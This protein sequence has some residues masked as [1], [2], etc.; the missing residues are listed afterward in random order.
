MRSRLS[1]L[2]CAACGR[3]L[4]AD[5]LQTLCPECG[6]VL[7]AR[8]DMASLRRAHRDELSARKGRMWRW[9]EALPVL[10][11][12]CVVSLGEGATP[13]LHAERIGERIGAPRLF[14]KDESGNPTGSFK[15]RGLSVAVSKAK[16]LGARSL[17]IPTAGNAGGALAAYAARAGIPADV[18][19]PID[20]PITMRREA[21]YY[22]A[23]LHLVEGSIADA[24]QAARKAAGETGAFD[25]STLK[26]PY[27]VEGKKTMGIELAEQFGW[28]LPDA[29]VYPTGG[30]TGIVGMWKAFEEMEALGWIGAKRPKMIVVQA[31]G[32]API[33]RAYEEGEP[34]A[35]AWENPQTNA[36]GLRVPSAVG[37]FLI[38][39]AVRESGG[40]AVAVSE[41]AIAEAEQAMGRYEGVCAAPEGAAALA[42]Y[43]QLTDNGVIERRES[44]VVFNT[45]S[46]L[47]IPERLK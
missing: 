7:F 45:G 26:E 18:F 20:A 46:G 28:E 9:F 14:T 44:V 32:C 1:H 36:P 17:T 35:D 39:N 43:L 24:G 15:A 4:N 27:R 11:P 23:R 31:E 5:A 30:G 37:D 42:G 38:L 47:K 25:V 2:E 41:E 12:N 6:L 8:Y 22:G 3:T 13:L 16:E 34:R 40:C 21:A 10:D 29:V 33:V 19:M